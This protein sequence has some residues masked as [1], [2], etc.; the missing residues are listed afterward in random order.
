MVPFK[1]GISRNFVDRLNA[2]YEKGGW[3]KAIA[4]DRELI[5]AIR[6]EYINVYWKGNS[7]LKLRLNGGDLIGE[8]H[9][10]YLLRP[11]FEQPYV[12]VT[13]GQAKIDS[14]ANQFID[15]I[16][17][18][19]RLKRAANP[20]AGDEKKGVHQIVMSNPNIVDVEI[21]FSA[22]NKKSGAV[23]ADRIDFSA[24]KLEPSGPEIVF[25]EAKIFGNKE[26]RANGAN[27]PVLRQLGRYQDFLGSGQAGLIDSYRQVCGNLAALSGVSNRYAPMLGM[28]KDIAESKCSL[29]ICPDVRLVIFGFDNDQRIGATWKVHCGKLRD[30]LGEKLLLKGA[31]KEF[32]T[33]ISSSAG[34]TG[35][36][37]AM[38]FKSQP[39]IVRESP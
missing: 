24:L 12:K 23:T 20:Y 15:D 7:L 21:A 16:S 32:T 22:E 25:Y 4:D 17:D 8:I 27:V 19:D 10:K 29:S 35:S 1:R 34:R 2:E 6:S 11:D 18:L 5:V 37:K 3:W 39:P 36:K 9:Y 30:A 14:A 26:L 33:G 31:A 38:S 28:M 13:G